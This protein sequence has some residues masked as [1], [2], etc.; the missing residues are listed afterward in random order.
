MRPSE[1]VGGCC[2]LEQTVMEMTN[3]Y[4]NH[5]ELQS[6]E[7]IITGIFVTTVIIVYSPLLL[8]ELKLPAVSLGHEEKGNL[9]NRSHKNMMKAVYVLLYSLGPTGCVNILLKTTKDM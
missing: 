7:N 3:F 4:S 5:L 9:R 8:I 6:R 1:G 2:S